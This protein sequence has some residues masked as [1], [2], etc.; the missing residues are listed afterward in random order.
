[1]TMDSHRHRR[2]IALGITAV[3]LL[4]SPYVWFRAL[5]LLFPF[6]WEKLQRPPAV[7]VADREGVPLRF[8]LPADQRWR[9]PVRLAELPPE[10][11]RALVASED[12]RFYSHPGV[13][14]LAVARAMVS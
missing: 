7:V 14:L 1:M 9:L 8:F 2:R 5:D 11:R 6:P 10:V 13:D 3:V 4:A 12:Q